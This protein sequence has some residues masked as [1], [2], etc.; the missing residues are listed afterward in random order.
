MF[1]SIIEPVAKAKANKPKFHK[2]SKQP[3]DEN[4]APTPL[5][6]N[7]ANQ[8]QNHNTL[9]AQTQFNITLLSNESK[10]HY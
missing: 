10:L 5:K 2:Q 8:P 9:C 3:K 4:K 1:V 6:N 7:K